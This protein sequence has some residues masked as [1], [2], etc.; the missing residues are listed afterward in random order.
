MRKAVIDLGTNTFHLLI[1][2]IDGE[3]IHEVYKSQIPVKLGEGG[4][5]Q[6]LIAAASFERGQRAL[7]EFRIELDKRDCNDLRV[8]ATSAIRNASNGTDFI[9]EAWKRSRIQ[10]ETITG[11]EEA[12]WIAKGVMHSLPTMP[13]PYLI[14]DIG[15]GSVEF[16]LC[17]DK[18]I[19]H[20]QSIDIGAARLLA[21]FQPQDPI[22]KSDQGLI[23]NFLEEK[24]SG[25]IHQAQ[26]YQAH[27][28]VGSAGSFESILEL[29]EDN[30]GILNPIN[31]SF[32]LINL[33]DFAQIHQHLLRST[34]AER[35]LMKGLAD[36][37][38]EMMVLASILIDTVLR[39]G[40][41]EDMYCS[42]HSLKE[43]VLLG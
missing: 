13:S 14:M 11:L 41:M 7:E 22:S 36:Y 29:I 39:M 1:A 15:G 9:E 8:V 25:I 21:K 42:T 32:F 6:H 23:K 12:E 38:V 26:H 28:L 27:I 5:D 2:E 19:L 3:H 30:N 18:N 40:R 35:E 34:K 4:I 10:I 17:K 33:N 37:R 31:P 43:G 24:L 16:I 20:K